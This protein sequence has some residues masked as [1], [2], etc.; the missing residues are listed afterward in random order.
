MQ[1][2]DVKQIC[3]FGLSANCSNIVSVAQSLNAITK[4]NIIYYKQPNVI[5]QKNPTFCINNVN[6]ESFDTRLTSI[7]RLYVAQIGRIYNLAFIYKYKQ[8]YIIY[9]R[10]NGSIYNKNCTLNCRST[11]YVTAVLV[12]NVKE[13]TKPTLPQMWL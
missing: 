4:K 8:L 10:K 1:S 3:A 2:C 13:P 7:N 11:S 5:S 6:G 12:L 9:V